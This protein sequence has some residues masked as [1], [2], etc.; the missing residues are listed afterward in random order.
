MHLYGA[1]FNS[2]WIFLSLRLCR[3]FLMSAHGDQCETVFLDREKSVPLL[4]GAT[5]LVRTH[6]SRIKPDSEGPM[7]T[8]WCPNPRLGTQYRSYDGHIVDVFW[9]TFCRI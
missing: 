3:K 2:N 4:S 5:P 6:P 1:F 9:H 7:Q 8:M